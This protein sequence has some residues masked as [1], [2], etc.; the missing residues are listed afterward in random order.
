MSYDAY[1]KTQRAAESPRDTEYRAF[2]TSTRGLMEVADNGADAKAVAEALH[3]NRSLW[4][5]LAADCASDKN[6]LPEETRAR[7]IA[8]S[9]WVGE[10][11]R[12]VLRREEDVA[13]LIDVNRIMMDGLVG[14]TPA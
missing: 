3:V 9:R 7:I 2:A 5:A 12:R 13:P 8:L 1:A 14:K 4:E 6:R 10:H 11:S